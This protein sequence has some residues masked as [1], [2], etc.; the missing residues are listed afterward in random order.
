MGLKARIEGLDNQLR[1][2]LF[3]MLNKADSE[4]TFDM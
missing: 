4:L 2:M 1:D 3:E